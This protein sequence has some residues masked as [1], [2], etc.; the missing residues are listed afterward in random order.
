M[1]RDTAKA[2]QCLLV[3]KHAGASCKGVGGRVVGVCPLPG[4]GRRQ[5]EVGEKLEAEEWGKKGG[6]V[7]KAGL[8]RVAW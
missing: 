7:A 6:G 3:L 4:K 2:G 5:V 8:S 1:C